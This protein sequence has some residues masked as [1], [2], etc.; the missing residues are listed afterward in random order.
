MKAVADT[1]QV[2]R[3]NL[4]QRATRG[5]QSRGAYRKADD[6]DVIAAIRGLVDRRPTYGYRRITALL[7][8]QRLAED[9][10]KLNHKRVYRLMK[11][12]GLLLERH[13]GRRPGRVHDG[14]VVVMRSNLRWCSDAFEIGCWNHETV[15]V[16]FVLD[17]HDR[18]A[19]SWLG[20]AGGGISG[21]DVRDMMLEAV[22][23]RFG[24]DRARRPVEWLSD[25]GSP[26]TAKETREFAGQLNLVS[27]FT[28]VQSPESN[29]LAEA[30]VKTFKR[31]YVR[32]NPL[33]D[34][35]T[36][37]RLLDGWFEDYNE[38][39]PHSRL[40]MRSPREFIQAM[41]TTA[42]CPV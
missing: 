30:F 32:V 1:L 7:N 35:T 34:A 36:V 28:P 33:P 9:L 17:A 38:N 27:C 14:K 19:I 16:G 13:S 31:D 15:R 11:L 41:S 8:R 2:A 3:S 40:G 23:N 12:H 39:H 4:A 10:P 37:L 29:G 42:A 25:N 20:V 18:E 22:E 26:Y 21:S 6:P 5:R 24:D